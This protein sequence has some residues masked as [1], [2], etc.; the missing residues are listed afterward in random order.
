[1][2]AALSLH[3]RRMSRRWNDSSQQRQ[4]P[5]NEMR[6]EWERCHFISPREIHK[7]KMNCS[8]W[9]PIM[10]EH[11]MGVNLAVLHRCDCVTIFVLRQCLKKHSS[12]DADLFCLLHRACAWTNWRSASFRCE[13]LQILTGH[14]V[15][16]VL[17]RIS[18]WANYT[19]VRSD[20]FTVQKGKDSLFEVWDLLEQNQNK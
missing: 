11:R 9:K 8:C 7:A 13:M 2:P 6:W 18:E 19:S 12:H 3:R 5:E 4:L 16:W 14:S 1:M 20:M 17:P 10:R 15:S